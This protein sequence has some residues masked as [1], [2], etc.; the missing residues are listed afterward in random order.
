MKEYIP[1]KLTQP[2]MEGED[3]PRDLGW[4]DLGPIRVLDV[5]Q[6][7]GTVSMELGSGQ[8][9]VKLVAG[10]TGGIKVYRNETELVEST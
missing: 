1:L 2:I 3:R 8:T 9:H 6:D 10:K 7:N 4:K 5:T